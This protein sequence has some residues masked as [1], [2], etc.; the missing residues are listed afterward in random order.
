[1]IS[2]RTT[3]NIESTIPILETT[4]FLNSFLFINNFSHGTMSF[5]NIT[6]RDCTVFTHDEN[7]NTITVD[8]N[9][10]FIPIGKFL[11]KNANISLLFNIG[12]DIYKKTPN[13][14]IKKK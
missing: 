12:L 10:P 7:V 4:M 6:D 9:K 8:K 2:H 1:M 11:K 14:I 3:K 13:I 5:N